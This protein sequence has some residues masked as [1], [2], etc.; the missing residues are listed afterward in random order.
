[1]AVK[2]CCI[3]NASAGKSTLVGVLAR[4]KLDNGK[5]FI[6]F[7]F[8]ELQRGYTFPKHDD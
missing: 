3:G 4:G 2:V 1:M 7:S 6:T 8:E 5:V